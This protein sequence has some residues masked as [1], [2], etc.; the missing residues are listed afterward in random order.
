MA[1]TAPHV[2]SKTVVH[3][4]RRTTLSVQLCAL[5]R[6]L[7]SGNSLVSS[8]VVSNRAQSAGVT[9]NATSIEART[10]RMNVSAIGPMK[11]P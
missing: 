6:P 10:A 7:I 5:L 8:R 4:I 3:H 1:A 2:R 11:R 9:V